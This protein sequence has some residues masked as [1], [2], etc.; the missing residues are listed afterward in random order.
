MDQCNLFAAI[1]RGHR[2]KG[3]TSE[4]EVS[5]SS[6]YCSLSCDIFFSPLFQVTPR[7]VDSSI[8]QT[9]SQPVGVVAQGVSN[10]A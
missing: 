5:E 8:S 1:N 4:D 6:S 3:K 7:V 9:S 2:S 10:M